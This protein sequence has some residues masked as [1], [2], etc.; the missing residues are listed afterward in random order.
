[1]PPEISKL[2][3]TDA[4]SKVCNDLDKYSGECERREGVQP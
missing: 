3:S 1:M 2:I 4:P